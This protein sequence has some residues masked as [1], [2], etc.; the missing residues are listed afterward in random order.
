MAGL[1]SVR[2]LPRAIFVPVMSV[3]GTD[4]RGHTGVTGVGGYTSHGKG[5][6]YVGGH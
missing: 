5:S 4:A 2:L 3:A 6:H 1:V